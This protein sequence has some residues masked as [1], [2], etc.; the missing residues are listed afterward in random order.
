[1]LRLRLVS[2]WL[3]S[4]K[5]GLLLSVTVAVTG[6][7]TDA[8]LRFL[9][10]ERLI[11]SHILH[12]S[13]SLCKLLRY[14]ADHAIKHPGLALK[15]YQIATEVF[16]RP[17]DFDPHLDSLV[18]VQVGRLRSKIA[19][20][21]NS[22]GT[23]DPIIVELPKGTYTVSF[24]PPTNAPASRDLRAVEVPARV[25]P[26]VRSGRA[27]L[28]LSVLLALAILSLAA[29]LIGRLTPARPADAQ[30][31]TPAA[32]KV[33]WRPFTAAQEAPWVIFSNGAFVG[34]PEIGLRYFNAARD[35]RESIT[36]NYTGVGEVLAV[37]DLDR[38]FT[39]LHHEIRVKRGSLFSLDDA[40]N[41]NLIFVG[42]PV[43]NLTLL[44]LPSTHHFVFQR[45]TSGPRKGDLGIVNVHP[46][47]G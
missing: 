32:F 40:Q 34:R 38:V 1:M 21:Y 46:R 26:P 19:E 33:F 18:R 23:N 9:Q 17:A 3:E 27:V 45:A 7:V 20:Y 15:E 16:G 42:S 36:D 5:I 12:G 30:D 31:A 41:N 22:E 47:A 24:H 39:Q 13:E 37:Y 8:D 6:H 25:V 2:F 28:F 14:L 29:L 44:D 35:S 11:N 4:S 43:E 10:V